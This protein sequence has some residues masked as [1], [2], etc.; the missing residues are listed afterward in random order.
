MSDVIGSWACQPYDKHM[1]GP[2]VPRKV[3]ILMHLDSSGHSRAAL[4]SRD[5]APE[6]V[7]VLDLG[8]RPTPGVPADPA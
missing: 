6:S 4:G 8:Y 3:Q 2:E 1:Q 5:V 7:Q